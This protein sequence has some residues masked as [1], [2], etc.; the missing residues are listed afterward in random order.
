[1]SKFI[2]ETGNG[3]VEVETYFGWHIALHMLKL[4]DTVADK[5]LNSTESDYDEDFV[6]REVSH[7][8]RILREQIAGLID[9][10]VDMDT[11]PDKDIHIR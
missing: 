11:V 9:V 5:K 3:T 1:M 6:N 2:I 8:A 10:G 4:M 7:A